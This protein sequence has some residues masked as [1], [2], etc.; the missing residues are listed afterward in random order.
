MGT[1]KLSIFAGNSNLPLGE[2]IAAHLDRSL[3]AIELFYF[4]DGEIFVRFQESIR[5][6]EV[7]LIQT[8]TTPVNKN[9]MELLVM[10][11]A[12]KRASAAN[13]NAVIP[14][15]AY[16][17]QDKKM[18]AREPV[19]AK[20]V[21]DLL[22]AAGIDRLITMDLHAGQIQGFFNVPVDH[23]LALPILA[24]YFKQKK[25]KNLVVV[26]PDTGRVK[27]AKRY[28]DRL[29][30][31]I[32]ILHK[33]RPAHN[34]AEITHVIGDVKGKTA[35]LIDDMIDTGGT[36]VTAAQTVIEHGAGEVY[37]TATHA[38]LSGPAID[39]LAASPIVEFVT[40]D[41]VPLPAEK[42]IPKMKVLSI[43]PL[44]AHAIGNIFED[45]SVSELFD[46]DDQP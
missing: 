30:G 40:T 33:G 10:V 3:G 26:S 2:A 9:L 21:A 22:S 29:G 19:T 41:T 1:K 17:R 16:A 23:L 24:R 5:G 8:M 18:A 12:A 38:V 46:G 37:A 7:F 35:L 39:R 6:S 31:S 13:I 14:Y 15:Y 34:V 32:A 4:S 42:R 36:L 27:L 28:A 25:F 43:A 45:L 11:D 20:L 44:F